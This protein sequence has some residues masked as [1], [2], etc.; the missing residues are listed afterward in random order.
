M[1]GRIDPVLFVGS[2]SSIFHHL[3]RPYE[4]HLNCRWYTVVDL[5]LMEGRFGEIALSSRNWMQNI[6]ILLL[7]NKQE[8]ISCLRLQILCIHCF[9]IRY[10]SSTRLTMKVLTPDY[11]RIIIRPKNP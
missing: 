2:E 7:K 4:K 11:K 5:G 10:P 9:H 6:T 8:T 3:A 1:F